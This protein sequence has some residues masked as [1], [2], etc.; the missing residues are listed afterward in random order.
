MRLDD[1]DSLPWE[2]WGSHN[3][4]IYTPDEIPSKGMSH[5]K[6]ACLD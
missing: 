3:M 4:V 6:F 5:G 1:N 2:C